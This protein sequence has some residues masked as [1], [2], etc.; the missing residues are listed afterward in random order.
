VQAQLHGIAQLLRE[1]DHLDPEAQRLLAELVEELST[2]LGSSTVP[3]Q[4]VAHLTESAVHFVEAAR[5]PHDQTLLGAARSRL[6]EAI[7]AAE[8]RA[9]VAAALTRRLVDALSNLGI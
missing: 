4:E 6:D 8:T 5:H 2:L 9:P 1:V 3:P 7:V